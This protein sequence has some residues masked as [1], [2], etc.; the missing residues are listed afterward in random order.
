MKRVWIASGLLF[1]ALVATG[2]AYMGGS[3]SPTASGLASYATGAMAALEVLD[4]PLVAPE[5]AF[6][7]QAGTVSL[8]DFKGRVLLV[9]LWATWCAPCVI[10]MPALDRLQADM[11]G[12][13]FE[14][15][16][17]SLDRGGMDEASAFYD[18]LKLSNLQVYADPK[19]DVARALSV[20]GLPVSL[21]IDRDGHI[22]GRLVGAAEWDSD[23]TRALVTYLTSGQPSANPSAAQGQG[24]AREHVG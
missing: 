14:V 18:R 8:P 7:S 16:A 21:L 2:A 24:G 5:Q 3:L 12:A 23:E 11:G 15:V 9:N 17:I 19:W 10:E 6:Q 4:E 22:V 1:A 20:R 13:D